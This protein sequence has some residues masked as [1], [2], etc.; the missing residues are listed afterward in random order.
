MNLAR[1]NAE[2]AA[3]GIVGV[4]Q[5]S[6]YILTV[7]KRG[8]FKTIQAAVTYAQSQPAFTD[9]SSAYTINGVSQALYGTWAQGSSTITIT[10]GATPSAYL[11]SLSG[12]RFKL[13][14]DVWY[15]PVDASIAWNIGAGMSM[16]SGIKRIEATVS[17]PTAIS[18]FRENVYTI[19][20]LDTYY[21]EAVTLAAADVC[22][23]FKSL[24]RSKWRG[25]LAAASAGFNG[26]IE[27]GEGVHLEGNG[28]TGTFLSG[29][30]SANTIRIL[31]NNGTL[32]LTGDDFAYP[33]YY[34]GN[35]EFRN[36]VIMQQPSSA[37]GDIFAGTFGGDIILETINW[38]VNP[39]T[40]VV[41]ALT[42]A[43]L[44]DKATARNV[45]INGVNGFLRDPHAGLSEWAPMG[46][47]SVNVSGKSVVNNINLTCFDATPADI[48]AYYA[49]AGAN[50]SAEVDIDGFR[51]FAP[52]GTGVR[53]LVKKGGSP[54]PAIAV[55]LGRGNSVGLTDTD[56][57]ITYTGTAASVRGTATITSATSVVV[58]HN[59]G[60]AP[61]PEDIHIT[62][63]SMTTAK[64]WTV[65]TI[66]AT[67]FTITLDVSGSAT[68]GWGI[69]V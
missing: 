13:A 41:A 6:Q 51:P 56:A 61:N 22:L 53:K 65:G 11:A 17:T 63:T 30:I 36:F 48:Y 24:G 27:F 8:R 23:L 15:Y 33:S 40:A 3:L 62:P 35:L 10:A 59:L 20:L 28:A 34:W 66:T 49:S 9:I 31:G 26:R 39:L 7:G 25:S 47:G 58:T 5:A 55:K 14:G 45:V 57:N 18:W 38:H 16:T 19:L 67:Q 21:A 32:T 46:N 4:G 37:N 42:N 2:L 52:N 50:N 43:F 64:T 44:V 12:L 68:F 29:P 1:L 54:S 60:Y 69:R